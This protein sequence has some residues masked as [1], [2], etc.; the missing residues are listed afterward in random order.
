MDRK[1]KIFFLVFFAAIAGV[2]ALTSIK[3]FVAKDY[4]VQGQIDCDPKTEECFVWKCDPNSTIEGEKCTGDPEED[5]WYYENVR[6]IANQIPVCDPNDENCEA[7]AC[8]QG[9][10]CEVTLCN[11]SNVPEGEECNDPQ[12]YLEEN[13]LEEESEECAEEDDE[14][15]LSAQEEECAPDDEECLKSEDAESEDENV[16][17]EEN[18][19]GQKEEESSPAEDSAE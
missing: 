3:Y 6:K 19:T 9:Q 8:A 4:Y 11:E 17:E 7:L 5:I 12:K 14:E 16:S 1:N 15:C 13:P 10:D 18:S 2:V